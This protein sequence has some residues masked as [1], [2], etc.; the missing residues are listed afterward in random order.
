MFPMKIFNLI[1]SSIM[2][3]LLLG[4]ANTQKKDGVKSKFEAK[5]NFGRFLSARYSLKVGESN[6]A[7]K[8]IS[9]SE[10][11][12]EDLTLA[13]LNFTS[14]LINGEF[15]KAKKF[16]LI[17][18]FKLNELPMYNLPD[19]VINL[20]N[21]KIINSKDFNF[22]KNQLPGFNL[23]FEKIN[24]LKLVKA[25]N[26]DDLILDV[27]KSNIFNLLIFEDTR[28]ENQIYSQMP[29]RNLSIIENLLY[30]GYLKRKKS[31]I[32]F[33]EIEN[34]SLNFNFDINYLNAHFE[35]ENINKRK[36]N[37]KIL[38]ANL[39]SYL[40]IRLSSQKNVPV[41]YLKI[42]NEISHHLEPSI[43][44]SNYY[45]AELYSK[46]S[47]F[48]IALD[49]LNRIEKNSFMFLY[50][51]IKEYKILKIIDQNRSKL[52][53]ESIQKK[54]PKNNEVRL[55]IANN[56]RSQNR[57]DKAIKIYRELINKNKNN[58]NY[59]YF[60]AICLDKLNKWANSKKILNEL[61]LKRPNDAYV[62]NYLS[63]SMAIRNENLL[64]AKKLITKALELEK[65]N[66]FFLDTLGWIQFK[67]NDIEEAI[68]TIQLAVE[69]E[70]NNS[71]IID[72]LGD[73]YYKIG[74]KRE[75]IYEWNRAL[76]GNADN[77]L[78]K[79]IRSKLDKYKK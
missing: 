45:L 62:L 28:F 73:I 53:L 38:F 57:C 5:S 33:K 37:Q 1:L 68:K 48:K 23:I 43:G 76:I 60:K 14:Y 21:E 66:G 64:T 51:K 7:S 78:K 18:P 75:A 9:N 27:N 10:N 49:K 24:Y 72:H 42:L 40:S 26:F 36:P 2:I 31:K 70:P 50:S 55:L 20:K 12:N 8:I 13:E 25:N 22:M 41:S 3:T 35:N 65:N 29:K 19:F 16:K 47:N 39:F 4:C 15:N 58:H 63:Y 30:L 67:L 54:Y 71:E 52:L 61:I 79:E 32:F 44:N 74:R 46:E 56:F 69:L 6:I 77:E 34:F 11:L 59:Y 17:A